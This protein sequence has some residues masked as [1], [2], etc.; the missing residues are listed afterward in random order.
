M[1]HGILGKRIILRGEPGWH[2]I[3]R[4]FSLEDFVTI[5]EA[6]NEVA[7]DI[8][9]VKIPLQYEVDGNMV[10]SGWSAIVRK[11]THDDGEYINFGAAS[12]SWN[13]STYQEY[14]KA[15]SGL[16]DR[17]P[18]ET[19]G[20]LH[21][22][23]R[24]F[25][26][27]RSE[28]FAVLGKDEIKNYY[29]IDLSTRPG[30]ANRVVYTPVRTVCANTLSLGIRR[31]SINVSIPHV[32]SADDLLLYA[33]QVIS[34]VAKAKDD[35]KEV[36]DLM[37]STRLFGTSAFNSILN[38]AFPRPAKPLKLRLLEK[39]PVNQLAELGEDDELLQRVNSFEEEYARRCERVNQ[40]RDAVWERYD[41][42]NQ[43][44]PE[45]SET[46]WAAYQACTEVSDWREGRGGIGESVLFGA[47]SKEKIRAFQA[48]REFI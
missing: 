23:A 30:Q 11:P 26:A 10:E 17:Y 18:V 1:G 40:I 29:V 48:C 42:F 31:S 43:D 32:K 47:R 46:V 8:E 14:G 22:G 19:C 21:R 20:V 44:H 39:I 2:S 13:F 27:L 12:N 37:A 3:G 24:L 6:I 9:I 25:I 5:P 16:S 15:L 41:I 36:F 7:G 38:A 4:V 34:E 45:F 35:V 33:A 28:D